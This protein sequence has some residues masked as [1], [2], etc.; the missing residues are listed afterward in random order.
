MDDNHGHTWELICCSLYGAW[1]LWAVLTGPG[2]F[3]TRTYWQLCVYALYSAVDKTTAPSAVVLLMHGVAF[4]GATSIFVGYS[5]M[6]GFGI[7][8]W[9]S[10]MRWEGAA[11][12]RPNQHLP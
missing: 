10:W 9:G 8:Y 5:V 6:A 3:Y 1:L 2:R 4:S 12:C 11:P 7:S